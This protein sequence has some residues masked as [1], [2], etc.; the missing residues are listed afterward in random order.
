MIFLAESAKIWKMFDVSHII[1]LTVVLYKVS[2]F[3]PVKEP[4]KLLIRK[5]ADEILAGLILLENNKGL[6]NQVVCDIEALKAYFQVAEIQEWVKKENFA[7]LEKE[8]QKIEESLKPF[9]TSQQKKPVIS[10]DSDPQLNNRSKQNESNLDLGK[11]RCGK[12]IEI[13]KQRKT[14]QVKDLKDVFPTISKR[15]L[16]RDFEYLLQKG[17]VERVGD[18]NN[19]LYQLIKR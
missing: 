1:K 6:A 13:L 14:A 9:L 8:Y 16:R 3:F 19:T 11:K 5:K 7:V 18:N 17:V 12:I 15:T 4:L 2:D 10:K